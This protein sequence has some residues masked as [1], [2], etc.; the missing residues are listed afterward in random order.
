M[1]K[2]LNEWLQDNKNNDNAILGNGTYEQMQNMAEQLNNLHD[3][4]IEVFGTENEATL[5]L[6][7]AARDI[8]SLV[9]QSLTLTTDNDLLADN[10]IGEDDNI[11]D[12]S[13]NRNKGVNADASLKW[14]QA[15]EALNGLNAMLSRDFKSYIDMGA[16]DSDASKKVNMNAIFDGLTALNRSYGIT[17]DQGPLKKNYAERQEPLLVLPSAKEKYSN[18]SEIT[19]EFTAAVRNIDVA[20]NDIHAHRYGLIEG[21][22]DEHEQMSAAAERLQK[23]FADPDLW[24]DPAEKLAA[25]EEAKKKAIAYRRKKRS[26][27]GVQY[28]AEASKKIDE[29]TLTQ[30]EFEGGYVINNRKDVRFV[31]VPGQQQRQRVEQVVTEHLNVYEPDSNAGKTRYKGARKLIDAVNAISNSYKKDLEAAVEALNEAKDHDPALTNNSKLIRELNDLNDDLNAKHTTGLFSGSSTAHDNLK[32]SVEALKKAL[33]PKSLPTART[34]KLEALKTAKEMATKYIEKNAGASSDMGKNR[35]SAAQK[36]LDLANKEISV[37]EETM[38]RKYLLSYDYLTWKNEFAAIKGGQDPISK[39]KKASLDKLSKNIKALE[40]IY[41]EMPESENSGKKKKISAET[42]SDDKVKK[43]FETLGYAAMEN[44]EYFYSS[45]KDLTLLSSVMTEE[46][47]KKVFSTCDEL[48]KDDYENDVNHAEAFLE[49]IETSNLLF[50]TK[51]DLKTA[52]RIHKQYLQKI[53]AE[54]LEQSR[55]EAEAKQEKAAKDQGN[56]NAQNYR[57]PQ[58]K[59]RF[60]CKPDQLDDF[61][62]TD[63]EIIKNVK[64]LDSFSKAL[65]GLNEHNMKKA[66]STIF[67]DND[68]E[69]LTELLNDLKAGVY[70]GDQIDSSPEAKEQWGRFLTNVMEF[71]KFLNDGTNYDKLMRA[72]EIG[73]EMDADEYSDYTDFRKCLWDAVKGLNKFHGLNI[74]ERE[75][76]LSPVDAKNDADD[77]EAVYEA[78]S[79]SMIKSGNDEEYNIENKNDEPEDDMDEDI[80]ENDLEKALKDAQENIRK[81]QKDPKAADHPIESD[82]TTI[83]AVNLIKRQNWENVTLGDIMDVKNSLYELPEY[84]SMNKNVQED[85]RIEYALEE[86]GGRLFDSFMSQR[87]ILRQQ[88]KNVTKENFHKEKRAQKDMENFI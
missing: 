15:V 82:F 51:F 12:T 67:P 38:N 80:E 47:Y 54:K 53:T 10:I 19:A 59:K 64:E 34:D 83:I 75:P 41:R 32:K 46:D 44:C 42:A 62:V 81:A 18:P 16:A 35:L 24:S 43:L 40:V 72:A 71:K 87:N 28:D 52:H 73:T 74:E 56:I 14:E 3:N 57:L 8:L 17:V 9:E 37:V 63:P 48:R 31:E 50:G 66:I 27:D 49:S 78:G 25:L 55:K 22:S 58:W 6:S 5:G 85:K 60:P 4:A 84:E 30:E 1:P 23:A 21:S 13:S 29:G 20:V 26:D 39:A 2:T 11:I 45:R 33:D 36:I 70:T 86:D 68:A 79:S 77:Y 7:K 65:D 61:G 69:K 88:G 76:D